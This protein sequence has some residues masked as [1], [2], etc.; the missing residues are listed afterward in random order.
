M[1]RGIL[2]GLIL[3]LVFIVFFTDFFI[4]R[5]SFYK[6]VDFINSFFV[7]GDIYQENLLLKQEIENLKAGIVSGVKCQVPGNGHLMA[8][9]FSTYPFNI[10]NTIT[11]NV[12]AEQGVIEGMAVT[13]G[14]NILLGR[15]VEIF[16]EKSVARTLFDPQW[17]IPV[18][19][20]GEEIDALLTGGLEPKI[21]LLEK[22]Q[23]IKTGDAVYSASADFPYGLKIGEIAEIKETSSGVFKEAT[24]KIF[25]NISDLRGAYVIDLERNF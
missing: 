9:I 11:L 8:K 22:S 4:P 17:Q 16:E 19:I 10:K 2:I 14:E 5:I 6:L 23:L 20:G 18:R 1:K 21:T 3:V 13:V 12:G 15:I 25:Y 24:L 7:R